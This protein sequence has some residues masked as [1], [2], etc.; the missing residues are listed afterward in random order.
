MDGTHIAELVLLGGH[1]GDVGVGW[2]GKEGD[3]LAAACGG[4]HGQDVVVACQ[5]N[6]GTLR[7]ADIDAGGGCGDLRRMTDIHCSWHNGVERQEG[8][9]VCREHLMGDGL[10]VDIIGP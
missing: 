4:G 9:A 6:D 8:I 2:L 10:V 3:D 1:D 7:G 5:S